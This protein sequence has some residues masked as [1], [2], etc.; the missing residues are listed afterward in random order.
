VD[1]KKERKKEKKKK[2]KKKKE[3]AMVLLEGDRTSFLWGS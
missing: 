1:L 3:L 2:K